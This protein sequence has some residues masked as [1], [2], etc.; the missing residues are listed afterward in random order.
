[1]RIVHKGPRG[2]LVCSGILM[3]FL[4]AGCKQAPMKKVWIQDGVEMVANPAVPL[5]RNQGRVLKLREHLRLK[6]TGEGFF[7]KY[8]AQP[9]IGPDGSIF[10]TDQDQLLRFSSDGT[11]LGNLCKPGQGPGE[12]QGLQRYVLEGDEIQAFDRPAN[13]IVRMT[14]DGRW[15]DDRKVDDR[16]ETM[17][18]NWI[19]GEMINLPKV[20]GV[21][22]EA[23]YNFYCTSRS[24]EARTRAYVFL[25]K[26]FRKPP[27][28]L[29]WDKLRWVPDAKRDLL[30]VS[31][32]REYGIELL[33]LNE[34]RVTRSFRRVYPRVKYVMPENMKAIPAWS[35]PPAIEFESDILDL[36]VPGQSLWVKTS[37]EDPKKGVLIDVFDAKGEYL[38]SFYVRAKGSIM[39]VQGDVLFVKETADDG[40]ISIVLYKNLEYRPG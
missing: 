17:T 27:V 7:F 21:L 8:P 6:D 18:R 12:F 11:F 13:K 38:D 25:G 16:F 32:T 31:R 10:L 2:L 34:G 30:F 36:F 29:A 28:M 20:E 26:F 37:T 3:S 15:L 4:W 23:K 22:A 14:M 1:M 9:E 24:D 35:R 33:D 39:A 5:S 19:V 40:T